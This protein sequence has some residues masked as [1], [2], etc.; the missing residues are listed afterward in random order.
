M[1]RIIS[2][3]ILLFVVIICVGC[4]SS[5]PTKVIDS[6]YINKNKGTILEKFAIAIDEEDEKGK[7]FALFKEIST[8]RYKKIFILDEYSI[9]DKV[10]LT[11]KYLYIFNKKGGFAGYDLESRSKNVKKIE[12]NF[13]NIDGLIYFPIEVY[14]FKDGYIYISYYKDDSKK[15]ILYAKISNKLDK[16]ES[17]SNLSDIPEELIKVSK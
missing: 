7:R 10:L 12:A 17:L 5:N 6:D 8:N 14:G 9:N 1:K 13:D 2:F 11:D 16:Y 4:N 15:E 3:I